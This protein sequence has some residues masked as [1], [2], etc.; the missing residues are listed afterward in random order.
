MSCP[1]LERGRIVLCRA[2]G[3]RGM[4]LNLE[5]M[6]TDCFS[7]DFSKCSLL[8]FPPIQE[9]T[10]RRPALS[11]KR[12]YEKEGGPDGWRKCIPAV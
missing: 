9:R 6:E 7:G 8:L 12:S 4:E 11:S 5:G 1:Y 3:K 2:V 10:S